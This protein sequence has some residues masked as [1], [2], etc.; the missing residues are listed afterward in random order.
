MRRLCD[1]PTCQRDGNEPVN[2]G[3]MCRW[4]ALQWDKANDKA[5]IAPTSLYFENPDASDEEVMAEGTSRWA[6]GRR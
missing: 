1:V 6:G 3:V 5:K 2:D 4:H